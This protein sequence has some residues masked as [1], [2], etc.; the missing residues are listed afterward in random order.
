[1]YYTT[2]IDTDAQAIYSYATLNL[3]KEKYHSELSYAYN[4]NISR[5]CY[6]SDSH[7]A[8]YASEEATPEITPAE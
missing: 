4:Q 5:T 1:M 6:I 3:A 8:I 7:G 2:I